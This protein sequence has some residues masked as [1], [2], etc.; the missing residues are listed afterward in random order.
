M[1]YM[2]Y[3]YQLACLSC[4]PKLPIPLLKATL[5]ITCDLIKNITLYEKAVVGFIVF[6]L[7]L[8]LPR[9][10]RPMLLFRRYL[11]PAVI[12]AHRSRTI[13]WNCSIL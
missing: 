8:L 9:R 5:T 12:R 10:K 1:Y 13:L 7:H 2:K 11:V 6:P 3:L 4:A